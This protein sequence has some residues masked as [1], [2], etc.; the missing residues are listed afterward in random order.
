[1]RYVEP[2]FRPPSEADAYILQATIGCSWNHCTY[3]A[4]YRSKTYRERPVG[5]LLEEIREAGASF[6]EHIRKVFIADGDAL[7]MPLGSWEPILEELTREFPK[8]R[9]VSCYATAMNLLEKSS[10]ASPRV[11]TPPRTS[12]PRQRPAKQAWT[13]H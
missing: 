12:R 5:E 9:R 13:S 8:L 6:G 4:M 1:M 10:N 11:P 3:C 7:A 2:L